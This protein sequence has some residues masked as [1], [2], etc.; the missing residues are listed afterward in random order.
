MRVIIQFYII[1]LFMVSNE[2]KAEDLP[3]PTRPSTYVERSVFANDQIQGQPSWDLRAIKAGT[4]SRT[5][6]ING[7]LVRVGEEVGSA[8]VIE[9]NSDSVVLLH[10]RSQ[11]VLKLLADNV[12]STHAG[13][14]RKTN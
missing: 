6:I 5:A 2:I 14:V 1:T 10:Q 13:I 7:K 8:R 4:Q 3:D 12:K 11:I 9:I